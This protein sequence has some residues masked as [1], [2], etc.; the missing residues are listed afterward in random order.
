[1]L[2]KPF[3]LIEH[4]SFSYHSDESAP[5]RALKDISISIRRG[6]YAAV[7]GANGSGKS[8]LLK[9]INALLIPTEGYVYVDGLNTRDSILQKK[10][11]RLAGMVFQDPESQIVQ[12]SVEAEVAFVPENL[13]F[14]PE[15]IELNVQRSL[16]SVGLEGM[17]GRSPYHLSAGQKQ[18][19]AIASALAMDPACILLDEATSMLDHTGRQR[20]VEAVEKLNREGMTVI[21]VTQ[22]MEEAARAERVLV[23]YEGSI[24]MDG[25]P[26][27][28]FMRDDLLERFG[29][30]A[31]A[32]ARAAKLLAAQSPAF[33]KGALSVGEL[34]DE[35]DRQVK[36][37][38]KTQK[39]ERLTQSPNVASPHF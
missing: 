35:L 25:T 4:L 29:L 36:L 28:I 37:R 22:S 26:S 7:I 17:R 19:L 39:V 21:T 32:P 34:L 20:V 8:T 12:P 31:P 10:I 38:A 9:H 1:V 13:G 24:E 14:P 23:L 3:V 2:L 33:S 6:E 15:E 30:E 16:R 11:R 27:E 18:L 5:A